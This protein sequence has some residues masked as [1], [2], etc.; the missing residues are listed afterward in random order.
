MNQAGQQRNKENKEFIASMA[1][2]RETQRLLHEAMKKMKAFYEAS[3]LQTKNG[4]KVGPAGFDSYE[5]NSAGGTVIKLMTEIIQDS[6]SFVAE[7][8]QTEQQAQTDYAE[9]V[10]KTEDSIKIKN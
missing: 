7:A 3:F 5:N 6:E 2:Q 8:K 9:Y 1:D 10:T 4:Q